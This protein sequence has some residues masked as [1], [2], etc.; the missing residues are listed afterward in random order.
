MLKKLFLDHPTSV[1]ESYFE[2]MKVAFGFGFQMLGGALACF[3]HGLVPG[4]C[5]R[6]GSQTIT[7]LNAKLLAKRGCPSLNQASPIAPH[8]KTGLSQM[9]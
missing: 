3:V 1:G 9:R 5:Q 6:T 2:H 8:S 7:A 4:L